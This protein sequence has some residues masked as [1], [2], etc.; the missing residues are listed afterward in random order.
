M[1]LCAPGK[2][3]ATA[4]AA[5]LVAYMGAVGAAH[6]NP[7]DLTP[8]AQQMAVQG[9]NVTVL[10]IL[11]ASVTAFNRR[12]GCV[13]R[14]GWSWTWVTLGVLT[15]NLAARGASVA[16]LA[17]KGRSADM[18]AAKFVR[19]DAAAATLGLGLALGELYYAL[20]PRGRLRTV[21]F[22]L[23]LLFVVPVALAL[24]RMAWG[25]GKG[26][27]DAATAAAAL[28]V[29]QASY[30]TF[31]GK[32]QDTRVTSRTEA[33]VLYIGF[34]GTAGG[35]DV[36]TDA[37]VRDSALPPAWLRAGDAPAR[38]HT[39]F[40]KMYASVRDKVLRLLSEGR[41]AGT[42]RVVFAGHSLGGALAT[43]A[44]LDAASKDAAI[45]VDVYT[46]GAPQVGDARFA[47]YFNDRVEG[48]VRVVNPF[49][50]VPK[51]LAAQLLHARGYRAVT[52]M[53]RDAPPTAHDL[54]TYRL[55]L[56]RP[57]WVQ[58]LGVV[59]P[60]GYVALAAAGVLAYHAWVRRSR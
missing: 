38:A 32:D 22:L 56:S 46:F 30:D 1:R 33:G 52:S 17:G 12:G 49:D 60:V 14:G 40:V 37:D 20:V 27:F 23:G 25:A 43:L 35:A 6:A 15:A 58:V 55:A 48:S 57:R 34:A 5:L 31:D 28:A 24:P 4:V 51:L 54:S 39:G 10:A 18:G 3:S 59:A 36:R 9:A 21:F 16:W 44:G 11:V 26:G 8:H 50:P 13:A 29:S 42:R 45:T 47:G 19:W 2:M 7:A 41:E 53:T